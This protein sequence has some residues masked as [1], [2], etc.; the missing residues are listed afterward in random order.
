MQAVI[1]V[2]SGDEAALA[3]Q[4]S[5]GLLAAGMLGRGTRTMTFQE[6]SDELDALQSTIFPSYQGGVLSL[7]VSTDRKNFARCMEIAAD[8]LRNPVFPDSEFQAVQADQAAFAASQLDQPLT[9]VNNA[10]QRATSPFGAQSMFYV[11]TPAERLERIKAATVQDVRAF[12]QRVIGPSN[13]QIAIVGD[14]EAT[15]AEAQARRLVDGWSG[16][17]NFRRPVR[18]PRQISKE[19][20][21]IRTPDKPMAAVGLATALSLKDSDADAEA[22]LMAVNILGRGLHSRIG[23]RLRG[24]EGLSYDSLAT[25]SMGKLDSVSTLIMYASC[26]KENADKA[27]AALQEEVDRWIRDG[28]TDDE[29][30]TARKGYRMAV[31]ASFSADDVLADV[32]AR[33]MYLGRT[34]A[35]YDR[36]FQRL[37]RLNA[38]SVNDALRHRFS[39]TSFAEARSGDFEK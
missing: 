18:D 32:L 28:I 29:L 35:W 34:M 12:Y 5:I 1:A 30:S 25:L 21:V 11:P 24:K 16:G 7:A 31:L 15:D 8:M 13:V 19:R 6:R 23:T 2:R 36:L 17:M 4:D 33:D 14:I 10:L 22:L 26:A 20:I 37:D 9:L 39:S 27:A 3:G 38:A